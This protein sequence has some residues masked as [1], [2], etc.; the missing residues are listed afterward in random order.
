MQAVAQLAELRDGLRL[1]RVVVHPALPLHEGDAVM[2]R[3]AAQEVGEVVADDV[4]DAEVQDVG[5]EG[6]HR[7]QVLRMQVHVA[8]AVGRVTGGGDARGFE[9]QVDLEDE[10]LPVR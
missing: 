4:R 7:L 1:P 6:E 10:A 2:L 9:A 3:V 8:E 5:E